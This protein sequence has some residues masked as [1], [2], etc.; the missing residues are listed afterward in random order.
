MS[1]KRDTV[2]DDKKSQ[3]NWFSSLRSL[4]FSRV[5]V[6]EIFAVFAAQAQ[7]CDYYKNYVCNASDIPR[8][9]ST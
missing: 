8:A 2:L 3:G 7:A 5:F 4:G 1:Q 6:G 9:S